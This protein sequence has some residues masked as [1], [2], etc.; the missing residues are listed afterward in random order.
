MKVKMM[1][2]NLPVINGYIARQVF[3]LQM[4]AIKR[5][6]TMPLYYWLFKIHFSLHEAGH[7]PSCWS[8]KEVVQRYES[9]TGSGYSNTLAKLAIRRHIR[10]VVKSGLFTKEQAK[11]YRKL[12]AKAFVDGVLGR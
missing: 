7:G 1:T 5:R 8:L 12:I 10:N 6:I 2:K 11:V 4:F 3:K 9:G